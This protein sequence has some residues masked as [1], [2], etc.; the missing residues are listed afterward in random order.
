[1]LKVLSHGNLTN[2][3][4]L[5]TILA[6]DTRVTLIGSID[7]HLVPMYSS[8]FS[9]AYHGSIFRAVFLDGRIHQHDFLAR[10]VAFALRLRNEGW[11]DHGVMSELSSALMG[12][13]Y[14]GEGHS[15]VYDEPAVYE[16]YTCHLHMKLTCSLALRNTLETTSMRNMPLHVEKFKARMSPNPYLLPWSMRGVLEET[17][18]GPLSHELDELREEFARWDPKGPKLKDLKWRMEGWSMAAKPKI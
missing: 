14:T 9:T 12:N 15:R 6:H 1:M 18:R 5:R 11:R 10:L 2:N 8:T 4:A 3:A 7:D 16:Y 13:F 17:I